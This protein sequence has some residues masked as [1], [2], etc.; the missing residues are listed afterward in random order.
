MGLQALVA[1]E[2]R[3]ERALG[4][5]AGGGQDAAPHGVLADWR[6]AAAASR[7]AE[8][9]PRG[10]LQTASPKA[11]D[12]RHLRWLRAEQ[13]ERFVA[14]VVLH[15]G[16][17]KGKGIEAVLSRVA[18]ALERIFEDAPGDCLLALENAAGQGGTIGLI[19]RLGGWPGASIALDA[20]NGPSVLVA[21]NRGRLWLAATL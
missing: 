15:T 5:V 6:I 8:A 3:G 21:G 16:S 18:G 17:H 14:G 4:E 13:P 2:A 12:A 20:R 9:G 10:S 11:T 1:D 19:R 7:M